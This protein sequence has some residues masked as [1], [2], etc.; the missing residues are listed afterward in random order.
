MRKMTRREMLRLAAISG[1]GA[2]LAAC[3]PAS[4]PTTAPVVATDTSS[5]PAVVAATDTAA[6][7]AT[8]APAATA[9]TAP[10]AQVKPPIPYPDP[11]KL[12][13]GGTAVKKL[14]MEQLVSYKSLPAYKQAPWLD[15]LVTAGTIPAL[16]KR[17]PKTPAVMMKAGMKDG[18][19]VSGDLWRGFSACPTAGY[20]DMAGTTMGWFGIE[21]YTT[22]YDALLKTGPLF[23]A[24]QDPVSYTH[25][26][27]PTNR[28]L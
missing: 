1:A 6:P 15:K 7:V 23:R 9:T 5:A 4:T 2:V 3:T 16:E 26:T 22:R 11:N 18:V 10:A 19:G 28:E 17:L 25:L 8:M 14:P 12:D 13:V 24:D 20:N 21:S 27:L